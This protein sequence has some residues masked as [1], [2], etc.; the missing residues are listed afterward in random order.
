MPDRLSLP[1]EKPDHEMTNIK[2]FARS[3]T[4]KLFSNWHKRKR[5]DRQ[6]SISLTKRSL[7]TITSK[8][9]PI[10]LLYVPYRRTGLDCAFGLSG[11]IANLMIAMIDPVPY[12][13]IP[14]ILI[15]N[16]RKTRNSQSLESRNQNP[17]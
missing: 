3:S 4:H 12:N 6:R 8:P 7:P 9:I 15:A 16:S 17:T 5:I 13:S 1:W 11:Q 14:A 2:S 10:L